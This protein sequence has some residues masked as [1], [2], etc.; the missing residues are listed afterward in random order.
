[1]I[2]FFKKVRKIGKEK[3]GNNSEFSSLNREEESIPASNFR[4]IVGMKL[5]LR[6]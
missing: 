2:F 6:Y 3:N 1:M 5:L 4:S